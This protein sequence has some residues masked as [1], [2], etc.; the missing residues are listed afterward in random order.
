MPEATNFSPNLQKNYKWVSIY[1]SLSNKLLEYKNNRQ[2]LIALIK[3]AFDEANIEFPTLVKGD[4]TIDDICPFTVFGT[5]NKPLKELSRKNILIHILRALNLPEECPTSFDGIPLVN[6]LNAAFYCLNKDERGKNDIQNLWNLFESAINFADSPTEESK[7]DFIN[8]YNTCLNIK[9]AAWNLTMGLFWI[10]P[11]SYISLDSTIRQYIKN[12][13]FFP[14]DSKKLSKV[15]QAEAYLELSKQLQHQISESGEFDS[16]VEFSH[17]LWLQS[18]QDSHKRGNNYDWVN[19]YQEFADRLRDFYH[20]RKSLIDRIKQAFKSAG[21]NLPTLEREGHEIIDICPFTVMGLFN[22]QLTDGNRKKLL[23]YLL[24]ALDLPSRCPKNFDGIPVLNPQMATFYWFIGQRHEQ[25]IANLWDMFVS[26]LDYADHPTYESR[27]QFIH[28]YD[29]SQTQKGIKWNLSMGLF[30]IRPHRYLSLDGRNRWYIE[31]NDDFQAE[32]PLVRTKQTTVPPAEEYLHITEEVRQIISKSSK[33]ENFVEFSHHAWLESERI[34]NEQKTGQRKILLMR[35]KDNRYL[36]DI[37]IT[38]E[39]WKEMLAN[40]KIF[41]PDALNMVLT[42]YKKPNHQASI[43]SI[44]EEITPQ[45]KGFPYS[46][47]TVLGKKIIDKLNRFTVVRADNK[48][49]TYWGIPFEGWVENKDGLIWKIRAELAQAIKELG[50]IGFSD[51]EETSIDMLQD[52]IN[53]IYE[54]EDFLNEVYLTEEKYEI[55]KA[56]LLKK[57]SIILQGAPGVGKTFS[58]ERLAWSI[59]GSKDKD[60]VMMIQFHQSYSYEDFMMGYRPNGNGFELKH[61]AFYKFCKKAATDSGKP[62]FFI[63]DEINRGNLSKI[64]GELFMLIEYRNRTMPLLY[65]D[66]EFSIPDNL[67][68]IG[69]MNTA[70]RSLAMMDYALRRR[71]AFFELEPAFQTDGFI[72]Y[73]KQTESLIFDKLI[74]KIEELNE[75]ISNDDSLGQGFR[76]GHSY[77]CTEEDKTDTLLQSIVQ[78]EII[79]L[80]EEYWFDEPDKIKY[81]SGELVRCTQ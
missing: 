72:R 73:K 44:I 26:A 9:Y 60:R 8:T 43:Q 12:S 81:W 67:H 77:F 34:N 28:W 27:K 4:D 37:D 38:V 50:L 47:V 53:D 10:R 56:K 3:K 35:E 17:K 68:I 52:E 57:K 65:T 40:K 75:A 48:K 11:E 78:Y 61:G 18:K 46:T 55:L 39:E 30:W 79:P 31:T 6:F 63:I 33:Y 21:M 69:M 2:A 41:Y 62:Y 42:W 71:F 54:K 15:P 32:T 16:F 49:D 74:K 20:D 22:K 19:I 59:L 80:L 29:Q 70:D 23:K 1:T 14:A 76:I 7:K 66:E 64:F 25:D 51:I 24:E 5:F 13:D 36:V 45:S 58:A